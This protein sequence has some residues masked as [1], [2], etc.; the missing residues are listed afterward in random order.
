MI[1]PVLGI[2]LGGTTIKAGV[3][4]PTGTVHSY[5]TFPSRESEGREA[6]AQAALEAAHQAT[7]A[8]SIRPRAI[9]LSIPG[10]V[11]PRTGTLLDLVARL[12][13]SA[14]IDLSK[15]FS[16]LEL[17]VWADNDARAALHAERRWGRHEDPDNLVLLTIGTG[18]GS[19][20]VI[21]GETLAPHDV[22][23]GGILLGHITVELAGDPC[24]CGNIGCVETVASATALMKTAQRLGVNAADAAGVFAADA[25]GNEAAAQA[26]DRFLTGLS[27]AIVNAVHVYRPS[28]VVLSGGVMAQADRILPTLRQEVTRRAWTIPRGQV[29]IVASILGAKGAVLA[30]AAVALR[31][32]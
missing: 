19:A 13:T 5:V 25:S 27:A 2:D 29:K 16:P 8:S 10:A 18:I 15:I 28:T 17:P 24:V 22:L 7:F 32:R 3:V 21:E 4:D 26:I 30:G 6:W 20:A 9:G 12:D 11:D 14:G 23:G 31:T 1:G